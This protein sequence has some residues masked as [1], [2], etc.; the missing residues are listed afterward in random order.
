MRTTMMTTSITSRK[1][2]ETMMFLNIF[3]FTHKGLFISFKESH[4]THY[5][6]LF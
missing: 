6:G 2:S 3:N 5:T 1:R 4:Y